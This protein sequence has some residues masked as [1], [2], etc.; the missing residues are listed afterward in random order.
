MAAAHVALTSSGREEH[1]QREMRQLSSRGRKGD[2][3]SCSHLRIAPH[4]SQPSG[5]P[6]QSVCCRKGRARRTA[7]QCSGMNAV[8]HIL[9]KQ[10]AEQQSNDLNG[11]RS[12]GFM[13]GRLAMRPQVHVLSPLPSRQSHQTHLRRP[14]GSAKRKQCCTGPPRPARIARSE[15]SPGRT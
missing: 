15:L 1:K 4:Q 11:T 10:P 14:S 13:T 7:M 9:R 8:G 2:S 12:N 5:S 3:M 6:H